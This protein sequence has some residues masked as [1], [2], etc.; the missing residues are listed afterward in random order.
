MTSYLDGRKQR[1]VLQGVE[2]KWISSSKA[3]VPQRSILEPCLFLI[4]FCDIVTEMR[5]ISPLFADVTSL[6]II[7]DN[8]DVAAEIVNADLDKIVKW[9]EA[10]LVKFNPLKTKSL[11]ISR[12]INTLVHP[13]LVMLGQQINEVEFLKRMGIFFK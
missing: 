13:S 5:T 12:K 1:I 7:V 2:S 3:G 10:L 8:P 11:P 6:F 9:A 4:F